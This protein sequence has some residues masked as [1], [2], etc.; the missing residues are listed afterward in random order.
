[1]AAE[2]PSDGCRVASGSDPLPG[3]NTG[4]MSP[5]FGMTGFVITGLVITGFA[6]FG[7]GTKAFD[8]VGLVI[9][10]VEAPA[11]AVD[12]S[13]VGG[14]NGTTEAAP[15]IEGT[16]EGLQTPFGHDVIAGAGTE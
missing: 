1:M 15:G 13:I 2:L 7:F 6:V 10:A 3:G 16:A 4:L 9:V 5:G 11:I 14:P 8:A 12:G